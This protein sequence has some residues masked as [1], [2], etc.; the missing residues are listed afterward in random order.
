MQ[1]LQNECISEA[2]NDPVEAA[3][4]GAAI[5]DV[6]DVVGELSYHTAFLIFLAQCIS[7]VTPLNLFSPCCSG[8]EF[9]L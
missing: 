6:A 5:S 3:V 8:F 1:P 4:A 9:N 2:S 7:S